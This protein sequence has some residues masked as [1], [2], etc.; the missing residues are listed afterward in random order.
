MRPFNSFST[1]LVLSLLLPAPRTGGSPLQ[2][3]Q[4][5]DFGN[6]RDGAPVK[7][8]TLRNARGL[9]VKVMSYGAILTEVQTPDRRGVM[10]NV[11]LSAGNLDYYL[12]GFPA[13]AAVIG[14]VANRIAKARF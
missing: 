11:V 12:N 3:I 10:T 7:L 14:R 2:R 6:M 13:S 5:S 8:F 4:E 1:L 9:V